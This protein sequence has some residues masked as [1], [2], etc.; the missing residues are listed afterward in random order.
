MYLIASLILSVEE[1]AQKQDQLSTG[2]ITSKAY[3]LDFEAWT[4]LLVGACFR[5]FRRG[6]KSRTKKITAHLGD[7]PSRDHTTRQKSS[8]AASG[9]VVPIIS[10]PLAPNS[11]ESIPAEGTLEPAEF[12]EAE[13]EDNEGGSEFENFLDLHGLQPHAQAL[14]DFGI[15]RI[16]DFYDEDILSDDDLAGDIGM[17]QAEIERFRAALASH[18]RGGAV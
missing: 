17:S 13:G 3:I 1:G 15:E 10:P 14:H 2:V 18:P 4:D 7:P 9:K 11:D 6:Q 5:C 16:A 8:S 12:L